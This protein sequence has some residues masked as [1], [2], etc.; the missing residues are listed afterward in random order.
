MEQNLGPFS[1]F[2]GHI[3][4][5]AGWALTVGF[6]ESV[7]DSED[8]FESKLRWSWLLSV[9]GAAELFVVLWGSDLSSASKDLMLASI[10]IVVATM[11]V[12]FTTRV[13][14]VLCSHIFREWFISFLLVCS[15]IVM[16]IPVFWLFKLS[17]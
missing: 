3:L 15:G 8:D 1:Q 5:S 10:F 4:P 14:L 2:V 17:H 7:F 9:S 16:A 12:V 11:L 13:R 6:T